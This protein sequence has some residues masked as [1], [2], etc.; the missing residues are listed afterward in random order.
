MPPHVEGTLTADS[1]RKTQQLWKTWE[2]AAEKEGS[3]HTVYWVNG[4]QYVGEWGGN[5]RD[6][7]GTHFYRNGDKYEGDWKNGM[8]EGLGTLWIFHDGKYRLRYNGSWEANVPMGKGLF[9]DEDGNM[10]EG[11]WENGKRQGRGRAVYGG[12]A[13]DGFGG[14]VYEGDWDNNLKHGRGTM[15]YENGDIYEGYWR[16]DKKSGHGTYYFMSKGKR[17]DGVWDD[18]SLKAGTYNEMQPKPPSTPGALPSLELKF[19]K[20]VLAK[21]MQKAL[22]DHCDHTAFSWE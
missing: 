4:A 20:Q 12:R 11:H 3:R 22:D 17:L 18:D 16:G 7:K 21:A 10:Y 14:N 8:R 15:T 6:G 9:Y 5:K 1:L 19:P 13:I 2:R